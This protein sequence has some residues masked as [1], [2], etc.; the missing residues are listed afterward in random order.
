MVREFFDVFSRFPPD[1]KVE[2]SIELVTGTS[3]NSITECK[4]APID[5][6]YLKVKLQDLIRRDFIRPSVSPLVAPML[7]VKKIG[8]NAIV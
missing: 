2:F 6:K 8:N 7:F 3:P 1:M 5:L 4:M